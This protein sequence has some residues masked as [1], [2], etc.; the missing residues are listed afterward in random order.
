MQ[1]SPS[2]A[3]ICVT[4]MEVLTHAAVLHR[5]RILTNEKAET[6]VDDVTDLVVR[7]RQ[8]S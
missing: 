5:P 2:I 6:F 8:K 7:Y 4:A 3:F 1:L